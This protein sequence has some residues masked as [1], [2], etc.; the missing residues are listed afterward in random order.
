MVEILNINYNSMDENY[1]CETF[2][3]GFKACQST[4]SALFR[5]FEILLACGSDT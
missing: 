3:S 1:I 4:K 2:Q 5:I